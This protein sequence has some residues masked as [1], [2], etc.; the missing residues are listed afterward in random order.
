MASRKGKFGTSTAPFGAGAPLTDLSVYQI[1]SQAAPAPVYQPQ[2]APN[3]YTAAQPPVKPTVAPEVGVMPTPVIPSV[4]VPTVT[5]AA[6]QEQSSLLTAIG[7][8]DLASAALA[9]VGSPIPAPAPAPAPTMTATQEKA[10]LL[11]AMGRPD[12]AAQLLAKGG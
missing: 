8:P 4:V 12:L 9:K 6:A 1:G 7:R 5:L 2:V 11:T 10:A 3:W